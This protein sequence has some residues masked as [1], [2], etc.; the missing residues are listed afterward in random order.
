MSLKS[1]VRDLLKV[2]AVGGLVCLGLAFGF[3]AFLF[4]LFPSKKPP[5]EKQV[6]QNFY[7]HRVGF[8]RLRDMLLEDKKLVRLADWG[9]QTTTSN[10]TSEHPMGD[11]SSDRYKE[12]MALLKEVGGIGAHRDENDPPA[13][14]CVWMYASGWAGDTRHLDVCWEN[15]TPTNLVASLDD[16]YKSPKPRKPAFRHMDNNWYLWADW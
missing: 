11:F 8:E 3:L 12:Y 10:G 9:V 6:I 1:Q 13:D 2:V 4:F 14:V 15:R 16:F 5:K 7:A